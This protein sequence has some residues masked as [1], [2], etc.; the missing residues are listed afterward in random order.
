MDWALYRD[1]IR[2]EGEADVAELYAEARRTEG[3]FVW[4]GLHE[5]AEETFTSIAEVL[6]LHPLAVEDVLHQE[7]LRG[8]LPPP[9]PRRLALSATA[10]QS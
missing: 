4:I 10:A 5:P 1:G 9:T 7:Q 6:G 2:T 8:A 3:A